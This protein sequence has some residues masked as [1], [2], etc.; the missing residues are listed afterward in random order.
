MRGNNLGLPY[1]KHIDDGIFELRSKQGSNIVRCFYFFVIG[2]IV[3]VTHGCLK[4]TQKTPK[5]EIEK[6]KKYRQDYLL[7]HNG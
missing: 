7:R 4:K 6:A 5:G 3:V 1:S 2:S